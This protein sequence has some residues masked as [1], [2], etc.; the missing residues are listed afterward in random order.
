VWAHT[1]PDDADEAFREAVARRE[2]WIVALEAGEN[3]LT[4]TVREELRNE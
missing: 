2:A 1:L 3:P 4:D